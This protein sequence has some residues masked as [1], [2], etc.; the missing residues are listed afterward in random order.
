MYDSIFLKELISP[1]IF[2]DA[3]FSVRLA[4]TMGKEKIS[5]AQREKGNDRLEK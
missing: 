2:S 4:F 3:M 5:D 1:K